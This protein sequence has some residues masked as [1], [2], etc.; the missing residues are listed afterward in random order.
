MRDSLK[1]V[2][3]FNLTLEVLLILADRIIQSPAVQ[4]Q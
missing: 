1:Y 3:A 2:K 4:S